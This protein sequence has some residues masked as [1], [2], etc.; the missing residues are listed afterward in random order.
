MIR[1]PPRST[2]TDTLF[3]YTTLF[4]SHRLTVDP[5]QSLLR[6]DKF[7]TLILQNVS[8]NRI[9]NAAD[10]GSIL[11]NG[12]TVRQSYRV[13]PGA[14]ISIVMAYTPRDTEVYPENISLSIDRKRVI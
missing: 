6:I 11:V 3:P 1:R 5:G 13:K 2:R 7:L 10:A 9:Q 12:K 4:R 14:V 8:R